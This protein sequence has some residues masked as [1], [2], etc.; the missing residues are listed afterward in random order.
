MTNKSLTFIQLNISGVAEHSKLFFNSYLETHNP[1]ICCLNETKRKLDKDFA[2]IYFTESTCRDVRSDGVASISSK[3]LRYN[4]L[5]ELQ[6]KDYDS[7]WILRV[8][9]QF[10]NITDTVYFKPNETAFMEN[11]TKQRER[12]VN[13]YNQHNLDR[14]LFLGDCNA[15]HCLWS[16]NICNP[17]GSLLL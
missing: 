10:K 14:V 11:F 4:C 6:L 12:V 16:N 8:A 7:H 13:S 3:D 15:S 1:T 9:A 17:N 5:N 2:A